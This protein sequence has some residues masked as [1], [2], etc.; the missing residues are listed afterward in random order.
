MFGVG[1]ARWPDGPLQ[2]GVAHG[3]RLIPASGVGV[4][5]NGEKTG[6]KGVEGTFSNDMTKDQIT[7]GHTEN[8][9]ALA[10]KRVLTWSVRSGKKCA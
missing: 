6:G 9:Q 5:V 2:S 3:F 7:F 4:V 10:P 8:R 1:S